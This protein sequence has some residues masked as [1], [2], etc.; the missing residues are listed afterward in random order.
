MRLFYKVTFL[1]T[2]FLPLFLFCSF[3]LNA[4]INSYPNSTNKQSSSS[5]LRKVPKTPSGHIRCLTMEKDTLSRQMHPHRGSL[6]AF[7]RWIQP[8]VEAYK[9]ALRD[10]YRAPI[11][12]I[13]TVF[14]VI[15]DGSSPT[16]ISAAQVQAQLDQLNLDFRNLAGSTNP[17]AADVEVEFCLASLDPSGNVML[18]PGINRVTTYGA[19]AFTDTYVD[20]TIKPGTIWSPTDYLNVWSAN[21]SGGLLGWAQ[22]PDASGLAGMPTNGGNANT[23]GVVVGFGTVGSVANPG[24]APPYNLGRTLTHEV[25]HWLGL[26]HIWGDANCGDD[27]CGDTPES[28]GSNFGCPT[29]TTCDGIQDMVENYM[30]YTDDGCMN[31][32]TADQ[33]ARIRTV[34]TV[35]PRRLELPNSTKCIVSDYAV[36]V[37]DSTI[38]ICS[39]NNAVYAINVTESGGYSDPV[40]LSLSGLPTGGTATFGATTIIPQGTTTLTI[41]N[42]GAITPG[43]YN[44]T[45]NATSTSGPQSVPLILTVASGVP[46]TVL[47]SPANTATAVATPTVFSWIGAAGE[48]YDIDIAT[49]V[50]FST[51]I[52]NATGLTSSAY[53][54]AALNSS[55]TYYWR[56]RAS[57]GCGQGA[58]STVF[59]FTTNNCVTYMSTNIPLGISATGTPTVTSTLNIPISG[60]LSDINV[61]D[62]AGTHTWINDLTVTLS[63]PLG[64]S[65][66]LWD[67]ICNNEDNFDLNFD[68]AAAPGALPC[69]PTGG[70]IYQPVGAL[71]TYNGSNPQ[72][73]WTLSITDNVDQDGGSLAT[74]GLEVCAQADYLLTVNQPNDTVCTNNDASY[75]IDVGQLGSFTDPVTLSVSGLPASAAASFSN[76]PVTPAGTSVLTVSNLGAVAAGSYNL[77]LTGNSTT[78]PQVD[79]LLMVITTAPSAPGLTSPLDAATGVSLAVVFDWSTAIGTN[80]SYEIDI[81][82]DPGF[83]VIVDNASGLVAPS[84]TSGAL[85]AGTTYYWR[86]RASNACG[87]GAYSSTFSFV[88]S[89]C[90]T[91]MSSNIPVTISNNTTVTSTINFPNAGIISD[92]NV[93]DIAGNHGRVGQLSVVLTSPTATDV[94]LWSNVCGNDNNFDLNFDDAAN[95]GAL[96]C[97]PTGGGTYQPQGLLSSFNGENPQGLWTLSVTDN[98]APTNGSLNT[99]GVEVCLTSCNLTG[100]IAANST[101]CFGESNGSATISPTGGTPGYNFSWDANASGQTTPTATGL[102]AGVYNVTVT[103]AG[104]CLSVLTTTITEPSALTASISNSTNVNCF[105]GNDGSLSVTA[106]GGV[107]AYN[108]DIGTGVQSNGVF[109]GLNAA[110]YSITVTD[111]NACVVSISQSIGQPTSALTSN[112]NSTN[113]PL[114]NGASNGA[115]SV[116]ASG[117]NSAYTYNLGSGGQ[118]NGNFSGLPAQV[119]SVTVTDANGCT[120][121]T[122]TT[123][124]NPTALTATANTGGSI[125]CAGGNDGT[126]TVVGGGGTGVLSYLWSNGQTSATAIGLSAASYAVTVTDINNCQAID[127]VTLTEP[128]GMSSLATVTSNYN[129]ADISCNNSSDGT[130]SVTVSGGTGSYTFIWSDGQTNALAT[131]LSGIPYSVTVT[132]GSGCTT[133]SSVSLGSPTSLAGSSGSTNNVSCFGDSDGTAT[134]SATGGTGIYSYDIGSGAQSLGTFSGLSANAY[135]ITITDANNCT[136]VVPVLITQP[137][138]ALSAAVSSSSDPLC[139]GGSDGTIAVFATGG[140]TNYSYDIGTGGQATSTFNGLSGVAYTVTVTDLNGCTTTIS[141]SL[142]NPSAVTA[143]ANAG[144]AISCAGGT[145]GTATVVGAGGTGTWS[146]FWSNGQ[147]SSIASGL[148]ATSYMVT[149]QD[150]NNCQATDMITLLDPSGMTSST[151]VS[152]NY[153]GTDISCFGATDGAASVSVSGGAGTYSYQWSNG[154]TTATAN[155]LSA[156]TYLVTIT[157]ANFCT[158]VAS[159]SLNSPSPITI[160]SNNTDVLCANQATGTASSTA[161][162]GNGALAYLWSDGQTTALATGLTAGLYGLIVTDVN[163]CIEFDSLLIEEPVLLTTSTIDNG[164]GTATV[165]VTGGV[166]GYSYNWDAQ[167]LNQSSQTAT[168]LSNGTYLVTVTDA[169]GCTAIDS[170]TVLLSSIQKGNNLSTFELLPNPNT[171]EF[172]IRVQLEVAEQVSVR[173]SNILGQ[174]LVAYDRSATGFEIP[175]NLKHQAAGVYFVTLKIGERWLTKKCTVLNH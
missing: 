17:A 98:S 69:P 167:A 81:A 143:T 20:G 109:S 110:N 14:H 16:N 6:D 158:T 61:V 122:S 136:D 173:V 29:Q 43:T 166:V 38:S 5:L 52:D 151:A 140:T 133:V 128:S 161:V 48:T 134:V 95:P 148:S 153:N 28:S 80:V 93:L 11:L 55:T 130:A 171:G 70:G 53:T 26:R 99:W 103:D 51:I 59:S 135:N 106:S 1:R 169:N 156:N 54:S 40:S 115:I 2:V 155:S 15:T 4:Q 56:V 8:Y 157:D 102:A 87:Q 144:A 132:D 67:Q 168:G 131:N 147:T 162:G 154:D 91:V 111:A 83:S 100:T 24:S 31:V 142:N 71:S 13:P 104:T 146:Y 120:A 94:T 129:G 23:D 145:N 149:V 21:L 46:T 19:G 30:D 97:P 57:N 60:A 172:V 42:I 121:T 107:A 49:D 86:V 127:N 88:T 58:F 10:G 25:G 170:V 116:S 9:Q 150:A 174:I 90:I 164:D 160:S 50:S 3:T 101:S 34:L 64:T 75:T 152:S 114:C 85:Q 139:N 117:G 36:S 62:L 89:N 159:V 44:L 77:V 73:V 74:W 165:Q 63:N 32:F 72:G 92:V 7:E 41:S 82:T 84:Y 45:L 35:S 27:F 137:A 47:S 33:K 96:P 18:E 105:G 141:T 66:T 76:N 22:F 175:I 39:P 37:L 118:G 108:F 123:L 138:A 124:N 119:Y 12:T 126:A 125:S 68:D 79:S 78:G 112:L 163:G 113:D 65:I